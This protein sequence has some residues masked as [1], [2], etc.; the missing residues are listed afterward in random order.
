VHPVIAIVSTPALRG[1]PAKSVS[2][3]HVARFLAMTGSSSPPTEPR[4]DRRRHPHPRGEAAPVNPREISTTSTPGCL[5][6]PEGRADPLGQ[7]VH[8]GDHM[9]AVQHLLNTDTPDATLPPLT[10]IFLD[11]QYRNA[12]AIK[13]LRPPRLLREKRTK[14]V[15]ACNK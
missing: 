11:R 4:I 12:R 15:R 1:R 10:S 5:P 14:S 8:H 6:Q 2:K 7:I 13:C 3:K 9:P